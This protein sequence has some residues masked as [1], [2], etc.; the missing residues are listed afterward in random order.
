MF[1][2]DTETALIQPGLQVPPL[3]CVSYATLDGEAGV[4]TH[5]ES[6]DLLRSMFESESVWAHAPFDLA[7]VGKKFPDLIPLIFEALWDDRVYDVIIRQKLIDIAE[8]RYYGYYKDAEGETQKIS[9][10]VQAMAKRLCGVDV[11]KSGDTYRLRY[12]ELY[13]VP[14]EEWP[15]AAVEYAQKD[16]E[17]LWPIFNSQQENIEMLDDQFRQVRAAMALH[18]MSAWGVRTDGKAIA[19]LDERIQ[20]EWEVIAKDLQEVGLLRSNGSRNT[21]MA[22]AMML[23]TVGVEGCTI[24]NTGLKKMSREGF[25]RADAVEAGYIGLDEDSCVSSGNETLIKYAR[26]GH[27]LKLRSTYVNMLWAGVEKPIHSRFEVLKETGRTS[28][29]QPNLQNLPREPGVRECFVPRKGNVFIFADYSLAELCSLAQTCYDQ[30]GY[31]HLG[32]ALNSGLDPHTQMASS[33]LGI[34]YEEGIERK[35]A[36]DE[37]FKEIRVLAKAAN[38]GYPGGLGADSFV[39]F[40]KAAYRV[41]I[42]PEQAMELKAAWFEAWREMREYFAWID[43]LMDGQYAWIRHPISNRFRG[44][45]PFTVCANSFFQGRTADGAKAAMAEVARRQ[46]AVPSSAL[47]GT[48]TAFFIHDELGVE[49]PEYQAHEAAKE[50][51][52]VMC[53][54]FVKFHSNMERA[55]KATPALMRRWYKEVPQAWKCAECGNVDIG[56]GLLQCSKC[57]GEIKLIPWD[58][59]KEA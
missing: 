4:V 43:S 32:D 38:F 51:E 55:V 37:K 26:Y 57:W 25:S 28:S 50:L 56:D 59:R 53:E 27:L 23:D 47:Y 1:A 49:A 19:E 42:T 18:L 31:S 33:I 44:K 21:K 6:Y 54:E 5:S 34:P 29:S 15:E 36:G 40:A 58:D 14:R 52:K 24:T 39:A 16:A 20:K 46:F 9:Y 30:F 10:S 7:V 45:I 3:V 11:D 8:G 12:G 17:I 2:A 41:I 22:K 35:K 13:D 48:H